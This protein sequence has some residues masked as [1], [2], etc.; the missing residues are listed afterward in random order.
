MTVSDIHRG[1]LDNLLDGVVVVGLGGRIETL[2][3]AAEGIL[4]IDREESA[5]RTFGELFIMRDGFDEFTELVIDAT[6]R[7]S[8]SERRVVEVRNGDDVRSLS[9][10]TSYLRTAEGAAAEAVAVILVFSDITEV[11]ELRE[12]ELRMAREAEKQHVRL[13]DAY[14][15]IEARNRALAA[16]LRKVRVAQGLGMVLVIALFLGAGFWTWRPLDLFEG[17]SALEA[18]TERGGQ[19]T[20]LLTINPR[21][22]VSSITLK[23]R[24]APW[25]KVEVRSP[26]NGTIAAIDFEVGQEVVEGQTL[27]ELDLSEL[28]RRYHKERL[29]YGKARGAF[30][31]LENWET[32]PDMASAR[33]SF[34]KAQLDMESRRNAMR[35]SEFLHEQG[36]ISAD[37]YEDAKR[38][39]QS[40][41]IDFEAAEAEFA[42]VR[43][44]GGAEAVGA[45]R[46][47]MES[48]REDMLALER[49][50]EESSVTAP[51]SGVVLALDR[52]GRELIV[53]NTVRKGDKL[54][55]IG[56][57][58]RLAA[59]GQAD[60]VDVGKVKPGQEVTV[61]GNAF[62][63]LRLSGVVRRV[64]AEADP[65]ARGIPMFDV[66][67]ML[68]QLQPEE[69][70][71]LRAGMSGQLRIVTYTNPKALLVP[72]DAVMSFGGSH[73]LRVVDAQT[74]EP[75]EREVQ[76]GPTTRQSVEIVAGLEAGETILLPGQ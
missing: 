46:Q 19:G 26:A 24:L 30:E 23:G 74:G 20:R 60:E 34:S 52:S 40:Q 72:I 66:T 45:A 51:V 47:E 65:K 37:E 2:N 58:S 25:R 36:L 41:M 39:Y 50:L 27:V 44:Q 31:T 48:A 28:R 33:R 71:Q 61:S 56:D 59:T 7:R 35:K 55:R 18:A 62:R 38:Q 63:E 1:V 16:A 76:I 5:G 75:R 64:A 12:T 73:R 22:V 43:A 17:A 53:G 57:F 14:R 69:R 42:T 49:D 9:V 67:V 8:G 32:S 6:A 21:R 3:P 4:G 11:S 54:F 13:Q 15:E 10:A 70:A 68:D 29:G